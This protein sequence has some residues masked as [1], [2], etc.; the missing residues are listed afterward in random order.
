MQRKLPDDHR[1]LLRLGRDV[2]L[3]TAAARDRL[4][5]FGPNDLIGPRLSRFTSP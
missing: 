4:A 2:G 1:H 5:S 3:S